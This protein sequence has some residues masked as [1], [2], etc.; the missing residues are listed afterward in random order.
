[1]TSWAGGAEYSFE[2][3]KLF[4]RLDLG[5]VLQSPGCSVV[6]FMLHG[7]KV[8]ALGNRHREEVGPGKMHG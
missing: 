5:K 2:E 7:D 3:E 6:L 1:M 8:G 4:T